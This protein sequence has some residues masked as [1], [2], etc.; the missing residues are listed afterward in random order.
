MS[1]TTSPS[2]TKV[3]IALLICESLI[4][5]IGTEHGDQPKI[6]EDMMR[7]SFPKSQLSLDALDDVDYLT[8][9][10][11]DVVHKMEYPSEEQ[12]D[13]YDAVMCSGSA[14]N[15]YAD[16]VEWIRKLIA[17]TV[18]LARDHPRV[19]IF[20][21]CFGHQIISLALGGTCVYNNGNW[22]IGP[23]KICLTDV[24]RVYLG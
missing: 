16:N 5:L 8:M 9:D 7:K 2:R 13:G 19:K 11:Y 18:H 1:I 6:F 21:F 24:G 15:A 4:P 17:F 10:S 12:I 23:T 14:A 3:S 20:G 22:E